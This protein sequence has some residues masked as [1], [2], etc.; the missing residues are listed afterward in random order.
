MGSEF[1]WWRPCSTVWMDQHGSVSTSRLVL[2]LLH[3]PCV[4]LLFLPVCLTSITLVRRF[5]YL[6]GFVVSQAVP[7]FVQCPVSRSLL[8]S[9]FFCVAESKQPRALEIPAGLT[10]L[11]QGTTWAFSKKS[12]SF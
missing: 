8:A 9:C 10:A 5:A 11:W 6:P 2:L 7:S 3:P 4:S 1:Q 12:F